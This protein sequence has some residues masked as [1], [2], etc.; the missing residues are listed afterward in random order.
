MG[1]YLD[2]KR[3]RRADL[4]AFLET[5]PEESEKDLEDFLKQ[6]ENIPSDAP[7]GT[8]SK[9][10]Q[11][12]MKKQMARDKAKIVAIRQYFAEEQGR[13]FRD[14]VGQILAEIPSE[15]FRRYAEDRVK[16]EFASK[17]DG[18]IGRYGEDDLQGFLEGI[19]ESYEA[20]YA[21]LGK[22]P[23]GDRLD[24]SG[25]GQPARRQSAREPELVSGPAQVIDFPKVP[26][27]DVAKLA[28]AYDSEKTKARVKSE[29][30]KLKAEKAKRK[31]K[32]DATP[33][34]A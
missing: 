24:V 34:R 8:E 33:E 26:H 1:R 20:E 28:A 23:Y 17:L 32:D 14:V 6:I 5:D 10:F 29:R 22:S 30:N 27:K 3:Q 11:E 13:I 7:V 2:E 18:P 21:G 12:S 15:D 9:L 31:G 25:R 4:H 19:L 16:T